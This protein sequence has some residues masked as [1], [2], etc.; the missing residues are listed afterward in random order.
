MVFPGVLIV[1]KHY[2]KFDSAGIP[3]GFWGDDIFPKTEKGERN[4]SIP[5]DAV[6]ITTQQWLSFINN[7]GR[8]R[9]DGKRVVPYERPLDPVTVEQVK[10]EARRR[11][12]FLYPLWRQ[13]NILSEGGDTLATMR[14]EIDAIRLRSD[15]I[16]KMNPAAVSLYNDALWVS[17]T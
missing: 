17:D 7:E 16:E 10:A 12:E 13:I 1:T 8:R 3:I 9:W 14:S 4:P 2:A 15:G 6:E 5:D 11:I